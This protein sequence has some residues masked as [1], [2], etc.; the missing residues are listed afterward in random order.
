VEA[1]VTSRALPLFLVGLALTVPPAVLAGRAGRPAEERVER[2]PGL[3]GGALPDGLAGARAPR[4]SLRDAR[5]GRA[6]TATVAGRPYLVTFLYASCPDACPL[7]AS[8]I[9]TAL[10]ALGADAS[11]VG[12]LVV[13][14]DPRGD[15]PRAARQFLR[16][17]GLPAS[18][19]YL[20]GSADELRPVWDAW[21][22]GGGEEHNLSTWLVDASGRL[23]AVYNG[24][25]PPS[26]DIAHDLAALVGDTPAS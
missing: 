7:T 9:A 14:V 3:R 24:A 21:M 20:L 17:Y 6:G 2:A 22:V 16:R 13:S 12:V 19:H 15:T 8:S 4:I 1:P 23:R 26:A 10:R 18:A 5:G 25:V 11:R